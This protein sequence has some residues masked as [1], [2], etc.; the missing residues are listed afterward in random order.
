MFWQR[1][2]QLCVTSLGFAALSVF[3]I[4]NEQIVAHGFWHGY[5]SI[6][7]AVVGL[8][9]LGGLTV[10]LVITYTDNILKGFATSISVIISTIAT[11]LLGQFDMM[12]LFVIGMVAVIAAT[13]L[14]TVSGITTVG[15]AG[16]VQYR[17]VEEIETGGHEFAVEEAK[18][19]VITHDQVA[20]TRR[21]PLTSGHLS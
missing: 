3:I 1:N 14:Y 17:Q 13:H 10:A 7:W 6:V 21:Y 8:Q 12:P 18:A 4:N 20:E 5:N 2:F 16:P 11:A 15:I 9:A 19:A